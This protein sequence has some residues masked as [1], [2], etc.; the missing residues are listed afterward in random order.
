[1]TTVRCDETRHKTYNVPAGRCSL[2]TSQENHNYLDM[3][4]NSFTSLVKY[5]KK[6]DRVPDEPT[7]KYSQGIQNSCI[8]SSL[9]SS[10]YYMGDE[11]AS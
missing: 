8:I 5:N 1:M 6:K 9:A 11:L 4:Y 10:L 7:I 3:H 2:N